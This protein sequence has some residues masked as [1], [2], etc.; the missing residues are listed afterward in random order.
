MAHR[1]K[2]PFVIGHPAGGANLADRVPEVQRITKALADPSGRL[3]LY[4]DRRLGKSSIIGEA[5]AQARAAKTPVIIVDLAKVTSVE[6]AAKAILEGLSTE[7]G[8]RWKDIATSLVARFRS[9][10]VQVGAQPDL[11]GGLPTMTFSVTPSEEAEKEP[12]TL[13]VETLDAVEK[14]MTSRGGSVGLAL[15]EFQRLAQWVPQLDWLLKGLFDHHRS[16]AYVLAGSQRSL[17]DAMIANKQEGGLFKMVDVLPLGP[18]PPD[19][20]APWISERAMST[21]VTFDARVARALIA[22]AGP[23]TR[24]VVQLARRLWDVTHV[25]QRATITDV[26]VAM[27]DL[28]REQSAHHQGTWD[29]LNSD[30]HRRSLTLIAA[31]PAIELTASSTLRRYRLGAKTT[32]DRT[33]KALI[34]AEHV[35][36]L[37][38]AHGIDD[39][40]FRRWIEVNTFREF[41]FPIPAVADRVTDEAL[42]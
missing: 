37:A 14:E 36:A 18:I 30:T 23:R 38:G 42:Q 31:N 6:G 20:F 13:L 28:V 21:G 25:S 22:V 10:R 2:N 39:P 27:D 8:R 17:I 32:V 4:G 9:S 3:L 34:R 15:D 33:L 41:N 5:A 16:V 26:A 29:R 7:L 11:V 1:T 35:V 40:F 12:G 19:L 24:D